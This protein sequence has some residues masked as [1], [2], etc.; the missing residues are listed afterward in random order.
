MAEMFK[1]SRTGNLNDALCGS[2][3][4]LIC[5]QRS[6]VAIKLQLYRF[7]LKDFTKPYTFIAIQL[8]KDIRITT[9]TAETICR[10]FRS[11]A[12]PGLHA[13]S[14][15]ENALNF[16]IILGIHLCHIFFSF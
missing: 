8:T 11:H 3:L 12:K 9:L 14:A 15:P 6:F 16:N 1:S 10:A 5:K 7:I 13:P 2:E 4:K